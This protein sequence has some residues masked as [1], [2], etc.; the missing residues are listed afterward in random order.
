MKS[1]KIDGNFRA[2]KEEMYQIHPTAIVESGAMI[3]KGSRVWHWTH[4]CSGARIGEECVLGQ[5][6]YVGA[7]AQVGNRV[8][9]QNNVSIYDSVIIEDD[10][11]C[12]PSMVFTNVLTPRAFV[13]R[14]EEYLKTI[15]KK[16]C[17]IG[18]NATVVCG[19]TLG[20]YS[21]VAAGAVV[22][23]DVPAY[24]LVA[25]VPAK[26]M[27]WVA[28]DGSIIPGMKDGIEWIDESSGDIYRIDNSRMIYAQC[29]K[30]I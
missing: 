29:N 17:S 22:T 12:G 26:Q 19:A 15:V 10:V 7:T 27:G 1:S 30:N 20:E 13:S 28:Q 4:V 18:A 21:M 8:K 16:G 25:G 3:G 14:K 9:I 6:V 2:A 24:A 11:F 5:N 23:K